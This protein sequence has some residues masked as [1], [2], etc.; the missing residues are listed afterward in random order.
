MAC[1]LVK[2]MTSSV[3]YIPFNEMFYESNKMSQ[4]YF[5]GLEAGLLTDKK[6]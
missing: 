5:L 2:T 6:R 1:E 4:F 3:Y